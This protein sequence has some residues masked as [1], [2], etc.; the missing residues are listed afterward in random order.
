MFFFGT[1]GFFKPYFLILK[2]IIART[3]FMIASHQMSTARMSFMIAS[4]HM[5]TTIPTWMIRRFVYFAVCA[6]NLVAL[7]SNITCDFFH[8]QDVWHDCA[9]IPAAATASAKSVK[10]FLLKLCL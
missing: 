6:K 2:K 9:D 1:G 10:V 3:S 7:I 4:R 8:K 5:S